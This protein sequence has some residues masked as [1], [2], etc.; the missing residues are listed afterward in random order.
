[1][2]WQEVAFKIQAHRDY[3][4]SQINP[5]ICDIQE[6]HSS[7]VL[8]IPGIVLTAEE[9]IITEYDIET[10]LANLASG[11]TNCVYELLPTRALTRAKELDAALLKNGIPTGPLHGLPISVKEHIGM[12]GLP[13]TAGFVGWEGKNNNDD[14]E[15]LKILLAAGAILYVRTTE[16]QGLMALETRSNITGVTTNPHNTELTCGGSSG[17]EAA[18]LALGGSVLGIGSDIG[19]S[20][21]SP[22]ANCGIYGFKPTAMRLPLVGLAACMLGC[23]MIAG[24]IGPMSR[25]L[26]GIE[27]FM[28]VVLDS[29]P[30]EK[31]LSLM[32]MPWR[33]PNS[34][35]IA[36]FPK[37]KLTIGVILDDGIVKPSPPVARA[38]RVVV[39]KLKLLPD[40]EVMEWHPHKHEYGME[41]LKRLYAPDGG[42]GF[43]DALKT[44]G[45][46]VEP[47]LA[48]TLRDQAGVESLDHYGVRHWSMER[49]IFRYE[50]LQKW[51]QV[52]PEMDVILCPAGPLPAPPHNTSRYWGYTSIWNL[53]DYPAIVFPVTKV[54]PELDVKDLNYVPKNDIDC[55]YYNNYNAEQQRNVPVALQIVAK[56]MED[57]K[58]VQS[59]KIIKNLIS[60]PLVN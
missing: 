49:E 59:L 34:L 10:L 44:S 46:P 19:G 52:A 33:S 36:S 32:Q 51:N 1:M 30:W 8:E 27:L 56:K 18:L 54:D 9:K 42:E 21:R 5:A 47:L 2:T 24:T 26:D 12:K 16:P 14:S 39:E 29:K 3:T 11:K 41:I 17:G 38:L 25:T 15:V 4:I 22:A 37:R 48:W 50:Y 23:D 53:L 28:K 55:W 13:N 45:E 60:L 7:R 43:F 40:V 57:E 20:I 58:T 6:I 35:T 31:D